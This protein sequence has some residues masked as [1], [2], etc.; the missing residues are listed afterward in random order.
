MRRHP[1]RLPPPSPARTAALAAVAVLGGSALLGPRAAVAQPLVARGAPARAGAAWQRIAAG[2]LLA[3]EVEDALYEAAGSPHFFVHVRLVNLARRPLGVDLRAPW[4]TA[5]PNQWGRGDEA[6]RTAIDEGRAV[7]RPLDAAGRAAL[8]AAFR[9]GG[10]TTIAPGASADYYAVFNASGRA[11]VDGRPGRYVLISLGGE[12]RATDGARVDQIA[13]E[14]FPPE[15][16]DAV[17]HAPIRWGRVPAGARVVT[18]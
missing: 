13:L 14:R 9:A 10:L 3:I 6:A 12:L 15:Q 16:P 5:Y 7:V 18:R 1:A 11:D 8:L 4:Q 17:V 2:P